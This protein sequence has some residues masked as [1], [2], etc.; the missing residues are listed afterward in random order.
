MCGLYLYRGQASGKTVLYPNGSCI[1]ER[2]GRTLQPVSIASVVK[3]LRQYYDAVSITVRLCFH[4]AS[5]TV[6]ALEELLLSALREMSIDNAIEAWSA[7]QEIL[8]K[9]EPCV[10]EEL[11][12]IG[13]GSWNGYTGRGYRGKHA[14]RFIWRISQEAGNRAVQVLA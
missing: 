2:E 14:S 8:V 6:Y 1:P 12:H 10:R 13:N 3:Q 7:A 4:C 11:W 9:G 5:C